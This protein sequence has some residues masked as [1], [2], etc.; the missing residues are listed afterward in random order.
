VNERPDGGSI[1]VSGVRIEVSAAPLVSWVYSDPSGGEHRSTN[2]SIASVELTR[3]GR[4]LRTAHG[5]AWE[6]GT[7]EAPVGVAAQP[8]PDP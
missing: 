8:F 1:E 5:G 3:A 4:T 7:R 6:L 2:C